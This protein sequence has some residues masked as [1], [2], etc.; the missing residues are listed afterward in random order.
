[1]IVEFM[2]PDKHYEEEFFFLSSQVPKERQCSTCKK[3]MKR[4]I[5]VPNCRMGGEISGYERENENNLT[6]GKAIDMKQK[7]V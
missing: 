5:G 7:W 6:L 1:M 2:C 4:I 3:P